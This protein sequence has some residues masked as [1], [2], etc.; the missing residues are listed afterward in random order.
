MT[1]H[2]IQNIAG[3]RHHFHAES[4]ENALAQP[5]FALG[6]LAR[7]NRKLQ[8]T[9]ANALKQQRKASEIRKAIKHLNA[10]NDD[11]LFDLGIT[12][13]DIPQVVQHGKDAL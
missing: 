2:N 4:G 12:R 7:M 3:L 10:M 13:T 6:F 11:Q 8:T 1:T 9:L 5:G